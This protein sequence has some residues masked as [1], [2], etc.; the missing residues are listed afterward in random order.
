MPVATGQITIV[1]YNDALSLTGFISTNQPKTQ[2]YN[3]DTGA[4]T[5]DFTQENMV[6]TMSLFKMGSSTDII[7][8]AKTIKWFDGTGA[9]I[10]GTTENYTVSGKTLAIKNNILDPAMDY[11]CEVVYTDTKTGLDLI[12]KASISLS[13][14][15]NGGGIVN[16][17][18][19][20]PNGNIFKNDEITSLIAECTLKRGTGVTDE[21]N[22]SYQWY[23]Y[24]GGTWTTISGATAKTLTVTP[25]DVP[26]LMQFKCSIKDVDPAS[27]TYNQTF[28]DSVVF[29]DQSDPIQVTV[30]SSA[31]NV[32]KNGEGST[33]L[34]A[35]LFRA[36]A[37]IDTAGTKYTYKWYKRDAGGDP[38]DFSDG[39]AN[40]TGKTM[41]VG[42]AE[43]DVKA[44]F[45]VEVS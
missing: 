36:G 17:V 23:K 20:T 28:E 34:T 40:K 5:P 1:D 10:T 2:L 21:T 6:L 27:N 30:D 26:G 8:Q 25:D 37:E 42:S 12:F 18:A 3:P 35:R 38:I 31:G 19:W 43:V 9:A 22:I 29:I 33:T 14:V 15:V 11:I 44:T 41:T 13:K 32:F 45:T 24:V 39:S 7:S 4:H 16:A